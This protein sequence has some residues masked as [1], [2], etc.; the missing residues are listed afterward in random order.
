MFQGLGENVGG[1]KIGVV[2]N[3]EEIGGIGGNLYSGYGVMGKMGVSS[4]G[5]KSRPGMEG[6]PEG[7][8]KR[9][10][11]PRVTSMLEKDSVM[12][13]VKMTKWEVAIT[14]QR[15]KMIA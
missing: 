9:R 4:K 3:D 1:E 6:K 8:C 14:F 7:V 13:K 2:G 12:K 11:A 10:R 5:G 15:K